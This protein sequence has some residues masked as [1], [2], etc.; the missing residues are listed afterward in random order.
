[1]RPR[2]G[3]PPGPH[4]PPGR[5]HQRVDAL[6]V[7]PEPGAGHPQRHPVRRVLRVHLPRGA[8]KVTSGNGLPSHASVRLPGRPRRRSR[9]RPAGTGRERGAVL[10]GGDGPDRT[11]EAVAVSLEEA[12]GGGVGMPPANRDV[13]PRRK[14]NVEAVTNSV[15]RSWRL[16]LGVH[17]QTGDGRD[18]AP[19]LPGARGVFGLR[20]RRTRRSRRS[21]PPARPALGPAS[22]VAERADGRGRGADAGPQGPDPGHRPAPDG[23]LLFGEGN[24][25]RPDL[26]G[27]RRRDPVDERGER[28]QVEGPRAAPTT[29][30]CCGSSR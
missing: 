7:G 10:P 12:V 11:V 22:S 3:V 28:V 14:T 15:T 6:R 9:R 2:P 13:T 18:V 21:A 29:S 5:G 27:A 8:G 24:V 20:R 25:T 19:A 16:I 30:P 17:E 4:P 26:P 1:M 23:D